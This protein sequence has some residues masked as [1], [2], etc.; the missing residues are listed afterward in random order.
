MIKLVKDFYVH[1]DDTKAFQTIQTY[2]PEYLDSHPEDEY[3]VI[4]EAHEEGIMYRKSLIK[5]NSFLKE[6]P[7]MV[8]KTLPKEFMESLK[9]IQE[10]TIFDK[11]HRKLSFSIVSDDIYHIKGTSRFLPLS[12]ERCKIMTMLHFTLLDVDKYFSNK[13]V[14]SVVIPFL[15][16]KIPER[17]INHQNLYYNDIINRYK[18][19]P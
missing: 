1:G 17:F 5:K 19:K 13:T 14:S 3:K 9:H 16:T 2:L 18:S 15:K 8:Q 11:K 4:E 10:E 7:Q 12:K 6:L